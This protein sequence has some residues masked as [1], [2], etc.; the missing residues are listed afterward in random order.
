MR[1]ITAFVAI[2]AIT[3][4]LC[5]PTPATTDQTV[6]SLVASANVRIH[7]KYTLFFGVILTSCLP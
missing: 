5:A 7:P 4:V 6:E 2:L 1:L 3:P